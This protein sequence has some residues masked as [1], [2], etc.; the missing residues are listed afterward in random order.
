MASHDALQIIEMIV[1]ITGSAE[2][3]EGHIA[4]NRRRTM[5]QK[6]KFPFHAMFR[7]KLIARRIYGGHL[8]YQLRRLNASS[9]NENQFLVNLGTGIHLEDTWQGKCVLRLYAVKIHIVSCI[10]C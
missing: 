8:A 1:I 5:I 7:C 10:V 2:H 4:D 6:E 3:F 9:A